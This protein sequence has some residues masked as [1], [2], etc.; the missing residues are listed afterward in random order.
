[1]TRS[2]RPSDLVM[3]DMVHDIDGLP[4]R[5]MLAQTL[6][7]AR[8]RE[9]KL[10]W[11]VRLHAETTASAGQFVSTGTLDRHRDGRL[12]TLLADQ[13]VFL[14]CGDIRF[15]AADERQIPVS[16]TEAIRGIKKALSSKGVNE[17]K[18]RA[19]SEQ[20]DRACAFG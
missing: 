4:W 13:Q 6:A 9:D 15:E 8:Q 10:V 20:I 19:I 16:A 12:L 17:L 1:M 2:L 5:V 3:F 7:P 18:W 14:R 11:H